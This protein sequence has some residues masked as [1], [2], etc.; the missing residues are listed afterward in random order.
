M[1]GVIVA[2]GGDHQEVADDATEGEP[3]LQEDA[4][5]NLQQNCARS[6]DT[7]PDISTE[8][9]TILLTWLLTPSL[10]ELVFN[11]APTEQ[12]SIWS[13]TLQYGIPIMQ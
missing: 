7:F 1:D 11:A 12:F 10:G 2:D 3:H 13:E 5:N 8:T 6:T 9:L 4:V